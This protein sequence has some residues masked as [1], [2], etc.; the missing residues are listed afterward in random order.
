MLLVVIKI[1]P[2]QGSP[3]TCLFRYKA[4][5]LPGARWSRSVEIQ[6]KLYVPSHPADGVH[7]RL[8]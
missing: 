6:A 1:S 2:C 4:Q 8:V 5:T 7:R 3:S